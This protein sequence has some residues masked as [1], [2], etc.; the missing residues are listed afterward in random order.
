MNLENK[1]AA[2]SKTWGRGEYLQL[3]WNMV[4]NIFPFPSFNIHPAGRRSGWVEPYGK[5]RK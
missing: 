5:K 2:Y 1:H 3:W 4:A